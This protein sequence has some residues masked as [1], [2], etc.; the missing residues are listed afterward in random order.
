CNL[1]FEFK[2]PDVGE[3]LTEGDIVKWLVKEG[4][5]VK[6]DQPLTEVETA[7]AVV[8]I[9]C[10]REGT[11]LKLHY[12]VGETVKVGAILVTLD[13]GS[14]G[15]VSGASSSKQTTQQ[16]SSSQTSSPPKEPESLADKFGGVIGL[17]ESAD[18]TKPKEPV[19]TIHIERKNQ[20]TL[21]NKSSSSEIAKPTLEAPKVVMTSDGKT[22]HI[23]LSTIRRTIAQHLSQSW[24]TIPHVM[25]LDEADITELSEVKKKEQKIAEEAGIKLTYLPF[26]VKACL[27]ALQLNPYFNASLDQAKGVVVVKNYYNI[28]IAV[29]APQ[30]LLVPVIK[31]ADQKSIMQLADEIS[32]LAKKAREKKLTPEDMTGGTFTITNIGSVGGLCATPIIN[33]PEAAILGLYRIL[34]KPLA[35]DG[36]VAIRKVLPLTISFDHRIIDGA[37]A[38]KFMNDIKEHLE[39]PARLLV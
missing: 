25:H 27:A 31:N 24:N 35:I 3:G 13:E 16:A 34:D 37:K 8:E 19:K 29:D 28:G 39:D 15:A 14:S 2:F 6:K 1:V 9:P 4:D 22:L 11:I 23:P 32:N 17:I 26:I 36:K 10:P 20:T 21:F 18:D 5:K 38:A 33:M 30:G 12:K 7:K